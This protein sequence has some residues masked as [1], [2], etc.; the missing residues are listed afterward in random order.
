VVFPG[1]GGYPGDEAYFL[2]FIIWTIDQALSANPDVSPARFKR[3]IKERHAQ[4][5]RG[6][7]VYIAHQLDF[8]GRWAG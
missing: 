4:I 5:A 3:W 1:Q 2:H 8:L 7:L 6:E